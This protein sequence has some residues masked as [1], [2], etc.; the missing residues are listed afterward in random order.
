MYR[1]QIRDINERLSLKVVA[2]LL[3]TGEH[4]AKKRF[5]IL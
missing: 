4:D 1:R 5:Y 2:I 3:K